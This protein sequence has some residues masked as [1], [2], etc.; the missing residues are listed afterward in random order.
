MSEDRGDGIS[1]HDSVVEASSI[2]VDVMLEGDAIGVVAFN[3]TA[4]T[5]EE[6]AT[7]GAAG[8]PLDQGR[9]ATKSTIAGAGLAPAGSTSIGAGILKG[10][11]VLNDAGAG[12]DV[13]SL[14]VLTDG[15]E[16]TPPWIADVAAQIDEFT[17]SVGLG[18]PQNTSAAALQ[19]ISG[20]HGG[21]LL[22]T[23]A[24]AADNRFILTKY[25][26]QILAGISNA[27]IVLDP[28]GELA[29]GLEQEIPFDLT[30]A[31][32][33]VDVILLTP[34]PELI[35]FRL[36]APSGQVIDP[37]DAASSSDV[38]YSRGEGN[39]YYRAVLPQ[40]L[41]P[42]RFDQPG[43]WKALLSFGN[44]RGG[45][46]REQ[47]ADA[48]LPPRWLAQESA[49]PA[50]SLTFARAERRV[51]PYSLVVHAYSNLS[52]RATLHQ[53]SYEPGTRVDIDAS[54]SDSGMPPRP[55]ASVRTELTYPDGTHGLVMLAEDE[56]GKFTGSFVTNRPGIYTCRIRAR[57][58]SRRGHLFRRERTLTAGVWYGGDR[59]P[60]PAGGGHDNGLCALLRCLLDPKTITDELEQRLRRAGVDV[61]ALRRCVEQNCS[62]AEHDS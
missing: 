14:L 1:K 5:L 41:L 18:T 42:G 52:F 24:I 53:G 17:Y 35:D 51:L 56:P 23:G 27:E 30:E 31:D 45:L 32:T 26:L 57:G 46:T 38:V 16:N 9:I 28:Q 3:E 33:G 60:R 49:S 43:T 8:D 50:A 4:V 13:K 37:S 59:D 11:E 58:L 47:P 39:A 19:A 61:A 25:F 29:Y 20:N 54:L 21:Y 62:C 15:M 7:L 34:D 44:P 22:L 10:R 55:G 48:Q 2:M 12:F 36:R 6:A 40:Q